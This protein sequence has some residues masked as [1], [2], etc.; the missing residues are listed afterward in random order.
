ML[1][2]N[3]PYL[4]CPHNGLAINAEDTGCPET[5]YFSHIQSM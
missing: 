1:V 5:Q 4:Y 2:E 3:I